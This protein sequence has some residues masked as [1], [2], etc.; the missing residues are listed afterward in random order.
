MKGGAEGLTL[1]L[2]NL[3]KTCRRFWFVT[4][5]YYFLSLQALL[6]QVVEVE[7][8]EGVHGGW[9]VFIRIALHCLVSIEDCL[10]TLPKVGKKEEAG[11][12]TR[13]DVGL[14]INRFLGN[15][16]PFLIHLARMFQKQ[17]EINSALD[18]LEILGMIL[19]SQDK[20]IVWTIERIKE[21]CAACTI[22]PFWYT[23]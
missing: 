16:A 7:S 1:S 19:R 11:Y 2:R 4:N 12:I 18:I 17:L 8:E 20:L 6:D 15:V 9:H 10:R 3:R 14:E 5:A 23:V 22:P 21:E 13:M